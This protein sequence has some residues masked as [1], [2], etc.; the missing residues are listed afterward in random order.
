MRDLGGDA[1]PVGLQHRLAYLLTGDTHLAED[2]SLRLQEGRFV[3]WTS[4]T[5]G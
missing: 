4:G 5:P 2:L 3:A 1:D